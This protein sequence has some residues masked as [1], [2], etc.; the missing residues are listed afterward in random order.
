[1]WLRVSNDAA[2]TMA[3]QA[4]MGTC[5]FHANPELVIV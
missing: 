4:D 2:K 1:M 3:I 5:T